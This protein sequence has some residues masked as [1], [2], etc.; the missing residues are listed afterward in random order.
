MVK[1]NEM[2]IGIV[3]VAALLLAT[4]TINFGGAGAIAPGGAAPGAGIA[5]CTLSTSQ[6]ISNASYNADKPGT[7]TT[8]G[9]PTY[10]VNP[11]TGELNAGGATTVPGGTYTMFERATSYFSTVKTVTTGCVASV[12]V[13]VLQKAVDT[14]VSLTAYE[15]NGITALA[16][17]TENLTIG[18]SGSATAHIKMAQ[19]AAFTHLSGDSGKFAVFI[20]VTAGTQN[21]YSVSQM[22]AVF[23]GMPCVAYTSAGLS[24]AA[25][26][27]VLTGVY[28][29]GWVCTGD[30]AAN[31]GS[32]HE[33]AVRYAAASG[34]NPNAG[35]GTNIGIVGIDRYI[36]G[37]T[38]VLSLGA[39]SET[40]AAIQTL[41]TVSVNVD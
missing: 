13:S 39:V 16:V 38:G 33:L 10:F 37:T 23:D 40:G 27:A 22:S 30:F 21:N 15:N 26:P 20:N 3:I 8:G 4:G 11:A 34:I 2:L 41:Q 35:A 17:G 12:P 29:T 6:T 1:Q 36:D 9:Y 19:S 5:G 31:D 24:N 14:A 25:T 7:A 32:I 28:L 18:A